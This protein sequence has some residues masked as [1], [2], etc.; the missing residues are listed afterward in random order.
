MRGERARARAVHQFNCGEARRRRRRINKP[1]RALQQH[2]FAQWKCRHI[3]RRSDD[4][5]RQSTALNRF[6]PS[7]V[8]CTS[9][10]ACL[11]A[12]D[13]RFVARSRSLLCARAIYLAP[14]GGALVA[15]AAVAF[16][17]R[18]Q[19]RG[20][21]W[22]CAFAA[23]DLAR[24][25]SE[26]TRPKRRQGGYRAL[27]P[28][29]WLARTQSNANAQHSTAQSAKALTCVGRNE[30]SPIR[31]SMGAPIDQSASPC[32]RALANANA[33]IDALT[34]HRARRC[35]CYLL[36]AAAAA[37]RRRHYNACNTRLMRVTR[38][39]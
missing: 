16:A 30:R 24:V 17:F 14:E 35:L 2:R 37:N 32:A 34:R 8:L 10:R 4:E 36:D 5:A 19:Q 38:N 7:F 13:R 29:L 12:D 22:R 6:V 31:S 20:V 33:Q 11:T 9:A 1:R 18:R 15:A 23:F 27:R 3:R 25:C 26:A 28:L 39:V 21:N